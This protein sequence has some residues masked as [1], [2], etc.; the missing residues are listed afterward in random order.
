MLNPTGE[1]N[2]KLISIL[3]EV[4]TWSAPTLVLHGEKDFLIPVKQATLLRDSLE[5]AKKPTVLFSIRIAD[6]ACRRK[7]SE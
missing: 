5:I 3:P 2:S 4:S 1:E 7:M 6:I